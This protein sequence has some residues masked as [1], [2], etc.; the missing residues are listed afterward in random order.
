MS[1]TTDSIGPPF[2][3]RRST[4]GGEAP[5]EGERRQFA[6]SHGDLS[7]AARELAVA[8][9]RYKLWHRRRFIDC[10]EM[11][12]IV[13]QLGYQKAAGNESSLDASP[14]GND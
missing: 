6:N 13:L 4:L 14:R 7:P 12:A 9:D 5:R 3:D 8:I 2:V 1:Q 10:E 11:L